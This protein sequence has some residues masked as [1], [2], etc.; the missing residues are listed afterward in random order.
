MYRADWLDEPV[1]H[2]SKENLSLNTVRIKTSDLVILKDKESVHF[3]NNLIDCNR[4]IRSFLNLPYKN[5][6]AW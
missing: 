2:F 5:R 1:E 6:A 3:I 4:W